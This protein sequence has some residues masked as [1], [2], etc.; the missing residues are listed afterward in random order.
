MFPQINQLVSYTYTYPPR[1]LQS[2]RERG[3]SVEPTSLE[4]KASKGKSPIGVAIALD[5]PGD[6]VG[7]GWHRFT[8]KPDMTPLAC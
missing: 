4:S 6:R 5:E 8:T 7:I 1:K 3:Y 2:D